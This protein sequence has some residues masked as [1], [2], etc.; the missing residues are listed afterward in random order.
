MYDRTLL[1]P[2]TTVS[3]KSCKIKNAPWASAKLRK[4]A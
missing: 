4:S 3:L 1:G 2:G